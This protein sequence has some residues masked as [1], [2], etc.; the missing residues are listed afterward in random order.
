MENYREE[1]QLMHESAKYINE[2]HFL[3]QELVAPVYAIG[4]PLKEPVSC[5]CSSQKQLPSTQ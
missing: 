2:E 3:D 1:C 4:R 5:Y